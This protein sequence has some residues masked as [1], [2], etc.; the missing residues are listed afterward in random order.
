MATTENMK[1]W[2]PSIHVTQLT[3]KSLILNIYKYASTVSPV[4]VKEEFV[5]TKS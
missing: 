4:V 1:M 2:D 3:I 5:I